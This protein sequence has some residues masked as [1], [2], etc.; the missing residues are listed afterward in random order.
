MS[1]QAVVYQLDDA[2]DWREG[3]PCP[4]CKTEMEWA[5]C[6][7]LS[8]EDGWIDGYEDDPLWYEPGEMERCSECD[9]KGGWWF[10]PDNCWKDAKDDD[11]ANP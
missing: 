11:H 3:H 5:E 6:T 4:R 10:C 7:A 9:G 2:D 1:E 8:C